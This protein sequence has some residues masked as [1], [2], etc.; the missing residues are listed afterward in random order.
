MAA[1]DPQPR[2]IEPFRQLLADFVL[3][4]A[5]V[6]L[7]AAFRAFLVLVFRNELVPQPTFGA[8]LRLFE[9][10]ARSDTCAAMWAVLP[11]LIL[12][13]LGFLLPLGAWHRRVRRVNVTIVLSLC[14]I[15]FIAD[16][17][18]FAEYGN[19]FDHWLFGVI[20]DDTRAIFTT[21]WKS[22][23]IVRLIVF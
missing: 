10:G 17:G 21:I 15:V 18:Y 2:S 1:T 16:V 5:L 12:T 14:A 20:Y 3:W 19:Q 11:S 4:L 9:T 23:P 6:F 7:F 22:Y 13:L 8:W